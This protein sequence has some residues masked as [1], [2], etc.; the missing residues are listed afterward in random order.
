M[1]RFFEKMQLTFHVAS[2]IWFAAILLV[3]CQYV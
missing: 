1:K 3:N 2:H